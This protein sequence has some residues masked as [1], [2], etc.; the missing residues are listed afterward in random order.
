MEVH[1]HPLTPGKKWT[2]YLWE[3]LMLFLAVF[4]GFLAENQREHYVEHQRE[5]QYMRSMMED[6]MLDTAEFNSKLI[7][8]DTALIPF[9][10]VSKEL[11][12]KKQLSDTLIIRKLYENVLHC[13]RF[14]YLNVEDRTMNQLKNSGNFRLVKNK[15]VTDSLIAYWK[16]IDLLNNTL[17]PGY[18]LSRIEV[19]NISYSLFNLDY[20][21]DNNPY[22]A[23]VENVSP[24]LISTDKREFIRMANFI[25]NLYLQANFPIRA[26]MTNARRQATDLIILIRKNYHIK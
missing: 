11:L 16:R 20:Y 19:K 13:A 18:E 2:H 8:I 4:C 1:H 7:F 5:K 26:S 24:K 23:L 22:S 10:Q 12:F 9:F 15:T 21:K 17:L 14:L 25:S 3:F 6:L